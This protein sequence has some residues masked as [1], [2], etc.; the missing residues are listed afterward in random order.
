MGV[1]IVRTAITRKDLK[2]IMKVAAAIALYRR[3]RERGRM[4]PEGLVY[5]S[6]GSM[7]ISNGAINSWKP[8]T[9][10]ARSVDGELERPDRF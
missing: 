1:E 7:T 9:G 5:L 6:V 3:L 10:F 4:A 8:M 2:N